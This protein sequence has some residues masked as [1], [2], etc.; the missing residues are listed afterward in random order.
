MAPRILEPERE[1]A[2]QKKKSGRK[3]PKRQDSKSVI[4]HFRGSLLIPVSKPLPY[5]ENK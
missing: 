3:G 4:P 2:L 1:K 5:L